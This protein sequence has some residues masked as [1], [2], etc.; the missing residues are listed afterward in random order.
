MTKTEEA[1]QEIPVEVAIPGMWAKYL[2]SA[3][4]T[5]LTFKRGMKF[6]HWSQAGGILGMFANANPWYIG[7]WLMYGEHT[8]G[9]KY[10]QASDLTG[11]DPSTLQGYQFVASRIDKINRRKGL[12][13]SHHREVA[14]LEPEQQELWLD[15]AEQNGWTLA[16]LRAAIRAKDEKGGAKT[17]EE[18]AYFRFILEWPNDPGPIVKEAVMELCDVYGGKLKQ[19]KTKGVKGVEEEGAEEAEEK[20]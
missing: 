6:E 9:E 4:A 13:F 20:E 7:D 16:Q 1:L 15:L 10:A 18:A 2:E 17:T 12:S 14:P 5:S 19:I 8:Y 11:L 3:T